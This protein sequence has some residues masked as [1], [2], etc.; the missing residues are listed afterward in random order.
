MYIEKSSNNHGNNVFVSFERSDIIQISKLT[1][2][3]NRLPISTKDSLK[4]MG[5]LRIRLLLANKTW[6]T[7][8][9]VPKN[10]RCS[11]AS[12]EWTKLS[13]KFTE[14]NYDIK[15]RFNKIDSAHADMCFSIIT[16]IPSIH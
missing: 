7:R 9:N 13:V 12:T 10:D 4:S 16:I 14:G 15:L 11:D 2:Y 1:I 8:Y 5:R 6:S 3:Q